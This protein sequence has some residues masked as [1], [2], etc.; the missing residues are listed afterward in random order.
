MPDPRIVCAAH[1]G[2]AAWLI[3]VAMVTGVVRAADLGEAQ[4][5]LNSGQYERCLQLAAEAVE[6]YA[7][8]ETW[9]VLKLRSE[10]AVGAY[11]DA[12]DTFEEAILR[13]QA[14]V[15]LRLLGRDV[16][17]VNN[18]PDLAGAM[19]DQIDDLVQRYPWR[20]SDPFQRISLG[21]FLLLRGTDA[22]QVL[23]LVYDRAKRDNP[24][25]VD[26]YLASG[27]LA[28]LKQD[29][30]VAVEEF[31][32]AERLSPDDADTHFRLA[33]AYAESDGPRAAAALQKTLELNPRHVEA[34]LFEV[35]RRI[36]AER[37]DEALGL[38]EQ[39][40][41]INP[42]HPTAWAYRAVI[43]HL[44]ADNDG[45]ACCRQM[46]LCPWTANPAVDHLI[47]RKLSQKYRFAEGADCQR[48]ALELDADYL[49]AKLQLSQ[50]LLRLGQVQEGWELAEEVHAKDG[51]NVLAYNLVTLQDTMDRFRTLESGPFVVRMDA[52]EAQIYGEEV[53]AL[54]QSAREQLCAK[55]DVT[56]DSPVHVEI[57]PEQK[58]FAI[59]TFGMPGGA[60]FLGVCFGNVITAN[61]PA[62]QG[63]RPSNW[64][65]VLWHEFCHV[66]TL[67]KTANKMPRWLSEGISV[68]EERQANP[69]WGQSMTPRYREMILNGQLSPVS[70]L[71]GAFLNPPSPLHLQ[72]A[73]YQSSLVVQMLI[74]RY[75][76]DV[77]RRVLADLSVGM[78]INE[79]LQRYT[80]SLDALDAEFADHARRRAEELGSQLDWSRPA[81]EA[82]STVDDPAAP[83]NFWELQAR[84]LQAVNQREWQQARAPLERLIELCPEQAEP[85]C[86]YELLAQVYRQLSDHDAERRM[87]EQLAR[88]SADSV[89]TY[90]RLMEIGA[91]AEDWPLVLENAERMLAVNPLLP[92]PHRYR[93]M[94]AE[95]LNDTPRAI[96]SYRRWLLLDPIDP[97]GVH[98]RLACLLHEAGQTAEAK[99]HV[100]QAL[101]DA[102][103]YRAAHRL[104][105]EIARTERENGTGTGH[106]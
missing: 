24:K 45:E 16:Y 69:A 1:R 29:Y 82:A 85:G 53:L 28:L 22:R 77:L 64:Q 39:I 98:Y 83:D 84:A 32:R 65:A 66:V 21:R 36:D 70:Q 59:R 91:E 23:E 18:R 75:G 20:Y 68:Y 30:A 104:L 67:K 6:L 86:A 90:L 103:R 95:R 10:L 50:D 9:R 63:E 99:R 79:S 76:L 87:L 93:A 15:P 60:G 31:T 27:D 54:L 102:P 41:G 49:P 55:Y 62:S 40:A 37:Y 97:A 42:S 13:H 74:D 34:M 5:L 81:P 57:F 35:D 71:S 17:L 51:Y 12:L 94:A 47:G 4:H 88:R 96:A 80:G 78:P 14:S 26:V 8:S 48:R 106:P 19:L 38:L 101:E 72:L 100:L 25:L 33:Q 46:A 2:L 89:A 3:S 56:I 92:D 43:A 73:Y 58:D 11:S 44:A 105:L 7:W 61:S 52:N